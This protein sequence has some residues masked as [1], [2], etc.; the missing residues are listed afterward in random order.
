MTGRPVLL[1]IL[2]WNTTA[3]YL[4][5]GLVIAAATDSSLESQF[6]SRIIEPLGLENTFMPGGE[7]PADYQPGYID[8][9][10]DGRFDLNAG[11]ADLERFG[12]AGALISNVE[13]LTQFAQALFGGELVSP[14]TLE[15]MITGGVP[16]VGAG[17]GFAYQDEPETGRFFF[18]NGDSYG[19][20]VRLRYDQ[21]TAATT[22]L[23]RNGVD[24]TATV[25]YADLALDA[26]RAA[27]D[28]TAA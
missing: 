7:V 17:L 1:P 25:D 26:L 19:W 18:A 23:F 27:L 16:A 2:T 28:T 20:T 14:D 13:D 3:N 9:D 11:E 15:E 6:H 8:V 12:G 22:V 4:L 5:L 10:G 24:L 21:D